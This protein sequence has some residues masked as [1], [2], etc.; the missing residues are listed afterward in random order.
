MI[1][2]G[3]FFLGMLAGALAVFGLTGLALWFLDVKRAVV[4]GTPIQGDGIE[5]AKRRGD[6]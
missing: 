1:D 3:S 2:P 4:E 5:R 6:L